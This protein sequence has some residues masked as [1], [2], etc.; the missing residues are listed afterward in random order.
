MSFV[1]LGWFDTLRLLMFSFIVQWNVRGESGYEIPAECW[2]GRKAEFYKVGS[3][4]R[5]WQIMAGSKPEQKHM[6]KLKCVVF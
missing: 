6:I 2:E 3:R 4:T 5:S 1:S